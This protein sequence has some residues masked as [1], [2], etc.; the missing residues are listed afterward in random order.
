[1]IRPPPVQQLCALR[2]RGLSVEQS[3]SAASHSFAATAE[4][5]EKLYDHLH[6]LGGLRPARS[7][8]SFF[9]LSKRMDEYELVEAALGT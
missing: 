5:E 4:F 1:M 8:I 6:A 2:S 3:L 7:S 9:A